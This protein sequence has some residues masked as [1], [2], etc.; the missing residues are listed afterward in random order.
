MTPLRVDLGGANRYT[1]LPAPDADPDPGL[2]V[3]RWQDRS[4]YGIDAVP[5]GDSM[6]VVTTANKNAMGAIMVPRVQRYFPTSGGPVLCTDSRMVQ[7]VRF[8]RPGE[9]CGLTPVSPS[10]RKYQASGSAP[11]I[12]PPGWGAQVGGELL[13]YPL[14]GVSFISVQP[15]ASIYVQNAAYPT[16]AIPLDSYEYQ[17]TIEMGV[18]HACDMLVTEESLTASAMASVPDVEVV[19]VARLYDP[20]AR[21]TLFNLAMPADGGYTGDG[22]F[23]VRF[24]SP[25]EH[26][27]QHNRDS[28]TF[29]DETLTLNSIP[30]HVSQQRAE[31]LWFIAAAGTD[32]RQSDA[33]PNCH[34]AATSRNDTSTSCPVEDHENSG[35]ALS[36][37]L[38]A[39]PRPFTYVQ[40]IYTNTNP[41]ASLP[42]K[43]R[44]SMAFPQSWNFSSSLS[45]QRQSIWLQGQ[46]IASDNSGHALSIPA[47]HVA[48]WGWG[49]GFGLDSNP[50][51]AQMNLHEFLV[52]FSPLNEAERAILNASL[53]AKW[54]LVLPPDVLQFNYPVRQ[55][56]GNDKTG[57]SCSATA[58]ADYRFLPFYAGIFCAH[59]SVWPWMANRQVL[60]HS[61]GGIGTVPTAAG[62]VQITAGSSG[63]LTLSSPV[64]V[65]GK[66]FLSTPA[67]D[68]AQS[69]FLMIVN[70]ELNAE[71][72]PLQFLSYPTPPALPVEELV[73]LRQDQ[74]ALLEFRGFNGDV[75]GVAEAS[76]TD[77][78]PLNHD[79]Y[80]NVGEQIVPAGEGLCWD[81][82]PGA[83]HLGVIPKFQWLVWPVN[84]DKSLAFGMPATRDPNGDDDLV[85]LTF[86]LAEMGYEKTVRQRGAKPGKVNGADPTIGAGEA[87]NPWPEYGLSYRLAFWL[88]FDFAYADIPDTR[89]V[90]EE[91]HHSASR[92]QLGTRFPLPICRPDGSCDPTYT[93]P[94][95]TVT[96]L[97]SGTT[98]LPMV[99]GDYDAGMA[100][101]GPT[102][103]NDS[104]GN[105]IHDGAEDDTV[106][107]TVDAGLFAQ[108]NS[109]SGLSE[110]V[111]TGARIPL[112]RFTL[113]IHD[114][115]DP[116]HDIGRTTPVQADGVGSR[117]GGWI[118]E[119]GV[120]FGLGG[121]DDL[122]SS[123]QSATRLR[124]GAA[125]N[126]RIN[127]YPKPEIRWDFAHE[128]RLSITVT[129][130]SGEVDQPSTAPAY[131]LRQTNSLPVRTT[132]R[133]AL[134]RGTEGN[135]IGYFVSNA[136]RTGSPG[137]GCNE[138]PDYQRGTS[139]ASNIPGG[140]PTLHIP[141]S[142]K[143]DAYYPESAGNTFQAGGNHGAPF[144]NASEDLGCTA[145]IYIYNLEDNVF[146]GERD[147]T[148]SVDNTSLALQV[149]LLDNDPAPVIVVMQPSTL[150]LTEQE[151]DPSNPT[152]V[153]ILTVQSQSAGTRAAIGSPATV[154][155]RVVPG[156]TTAA[157]ED[158]VL[159]QTAVIAAGSDTAEAVLRAN[160]NGA[161]G[162]SKTVV[163]EV[164]LGERLAGIN[165]AAGQQRQYT[166]TIE[167]NEAA[168]FSLGPEEIDLD[169]TGAPDFLNVSLGSRPIRDL[170]V[171][172]S[173][174]TG[175]TS[176]LRLGEDPM[177]ALAAVDLTFSPSN[178][179]VPQRVQATPVFDARVLD[180]ETIITVAVV[181]AQAD[182]PY[183][184]LAAETVPVAVD[185]DNP[186]GFAVSP[187]AL[188]IL[189]SVGG[190]VQVDT[191]S[192]QLLAQPSYVQ[193]AACM[194]S[195]SCETVV[196]AVANLAPASSC[197]EV[198]IEDLTDAQC[199]ASVAR[200]L[201]FTPSNWNI[202]QTVTVETVDD[203]I[204][205]D[206]V[207]ALTVRYDTSQSSPITSMGS[208]LPHSF[209]SPAPSAQDV[210]ITLVNDDVAG[211]RLH[212]NQSVDELGRIEIDESGIDSIGNIL[213][214]LG[215]QPENG[216]VIEARVMDGGEAV[217]RLTDDPA[218]YAVPGQ[219]VSP[220]AWR[221]S[222]PVGIAGIDDDFGFDRTATV[223][224]DAAASA[225]ATYSVALPLAVEVL[226]V[227]NDERPGLA[228]NTTAVTVAEPQSG[229]IPQRASIVVR[230][231]AR[232]QSPVGVVVESEDPGEVS[233]SLRNVQIIQPEDWDEG[234]TFTVFGINDENKGDDI[235]VVTVAVEQGDT[236]DASFHTAPSTILVT[237]TD[238]EQAGFLVHAAD[239]SEIFDAEV[240]ESLSADATPVVL[241]ASLQVPPEMGT[242]QVVLA[243]SVRDEGL[244][245][246]E[247]LL[248]D[249]AQ[250]A[251]ACAD[252]TL[253][254]STVTLTFPFNDW[255][256]PQAF[257]AC[258]VNDDSF[259]AT[260]VTLRFDSN[261]PSYAVNPSRLLP[262][263]I[264]DDEIAGVS[265]DPTAL[266]IAEGSS[267]TFE[268]TLLSQPPPGDF[269]LFQISACTTLAAS[270]TE[271]DFVLLSG[272]FRVSNGNLDSLTA[273]LTVT[274]V[275]D[276][277]IG[278][279]TLSLRLLTLAS[280]EFGELT[281]TPLSVT[282]EDDDRIGFATTSSQLTMAEGATASYSFTLL[283]CP[284]DGNVVVSMGV[285]DPRADGEDPAADALR[286]AFDGSVTV[287]PE[288]ITLNCASAGQPQIVAVTANDDMLF[289]DRSMLANA[290]RIDHTVAS[291]DSR[292]DDVAR[293]LA[294]VR[295]GLGGVPDALLAPVTVQVTNDNDM[296]TVRLAQETIGEEFTE[297]NEGSASFQVRQ[298]TRAES[299][300]R[301]TLEDL[302]DAAAQRGADYILVPMDDGG[303]VII[304]PYTLETPVMV[305][306]QDDDVYE[307]TERLGILATAVEGARLS[308]VAAER[309]VSFQILDDELIPTVSLSLST[310]E[311]PERQSDDSPAPAVVLTAALGHETTGTV[312]VIIDVISNRDDLP[313]SYP[314]RLSVNLADSA[315][316]LPAAPSPD[317]RVGSSVDIGDDGNPRIVLSV[318]A[319]ALTASTDIFVIAD[320]EIDNELLWL[321]IAQVQGPAVI[322]SP[323]S[324]ATL[325]ILEDA[326]PPVI[327]VTAT[328]TAE[329]VS[330]AKV[331]FTWH[332]ATDALTLAAELV[333]F[334]FI[335]DRPF[336]P[337]A[338]VLDDESRIGELSRQ[339]RSAAGLVYPEDVP[340][341]S[342]LTGFVSETVSAVVVHE[343]LLPSSS[344]YATVMVQDK[345]GN[346]SLYSA[347][348]ISFSTDAPEDLNGDGLADHLSDVTATVGFTDTDRDGVS[349]AVEQ[350]LV[351][352]LA[353]LGLVAD[354][355]SQTA[356]SALTDGNENGIPD[357]VEA[358]LGLPL[359]FA[360]A[361]AI[362]GDSTAR[363]VVTVPPNE[364]AMA[365]VS[366][367]MNTPVRVTV[368]AVDGERAMEPQPYFRR[369]QLCGARPADLN[370]DILERAV[371]PS[372]YPTA[373]RPVPRAPDGAL[374]LRPGQNRIWWIAVD[375]DGNWPLGG[376][377]AQTI[378]VLPQVSFQ[379]DH[380]LPIGTDLPIILALDGDPVFLEGETTLLQF[381]FRVD[382]DDA[383][384]EA[385]SN[386][387]DPQIVEIEQNERMAVFMARSGNSGAAILNLV[388]G[389]PPFAQD[390]DRIDLATERVV[391]GIKGQ[392]QVVTV[393]DN[394]P[395]V[396]S[397][398]V[399]QGNRLTTGINPAGIAVLEVRSSVADSILDRP[400]L[401]WDWSGTSP[402]LLPTE[403]SIS[404]FQSNISNLLRE[405]PGV[406]E[407]FRVAV[408]VSDGENAVLR[409][410]TVRVERVEEILRAD[411]DSDGDGLADADEGRTDADT[412]GIPNY[413]D[414]LT[415][416]AHVLQSRRSST[417]IVP[418]PDRYL[419]AARPGFRMRLG[420]VALR[421]AKET[422]VDL[423]GIE[424]SEREHRFT[425]RVPLADV[426]PGAA[427]AGASVPVDAVG[428]YDFL[429]DGIGV[430]DS[431]AVTLPLAAPAPATPAYSQYHAARG[432][433]IF[434]DRSGDRALSLPGVDGFCPSPGAKAWE[435]AGELS[436][437]HRCV[438]LSLR[439]G[440]P[441]DVDG[442]A[443]GV[444]AHLGGVAQSILLSGIDAGSSGGSGAGGGCALVGDARAADAAL[445]LLLLLCLLSRR[446]RNAPAVALAVALT[447][448]LLP[449]GARGADAGPEWGATTG[450]LLRNVYFGAGLASTEVAPGLFGSRYRLG[451][452]NDSGPRL[453]LGY[454]LASHWSL[455]AFWADLGKA[456][457][458]DTRAAAP[459]Y[460]DYRERGALLSYRRA[461]PAWLGLGRGLETLGVAWGWFV[462][463]GWSDQNAKC[464][465]CQFANVDAGQPVLGLGIDVA[466]PS[467]WTVRLHYER[468]GDDASSVALSWLFGAAAAPGGGR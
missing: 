81:F 401:T 186:P 237:V 198:L 70:G 42:Q 90:V 35:A 126:L 397:L 109:L 258:A 62:P 424:D 329:V 349:D 308:G 213:I 396:V 23:R 324:T 102:A 219:A 21:Q 263:K 95:G 14:A 153:A 384:V 317:Y 249:G 55:Q 156:M 49:W 458:I 312:T 52:F 242:S 191:F 107:F 386:I 406:V 243:V 71:N 120:W 182:D 230:L 445:A 296:P 101:I 149:T 105:G 64:G 65:D 292:Y 238:N 201:T 174:P 163:V 373:C 321:Q 309:Q 262:V 455:E 3:Q 239:G 355:G 250:S 435:A 459:A 371:L 141:R 352:R 84:I 323:P 389:S 103:A 416:D 25:Y 6:R 351:N 180:R 173:I 465:G 208:P 142:Y 195:V 203:S 73:N 411:L 412:D 164:S 234:F 368:S 177:Q 96:T 175:D 148:L 354:A 453:A 246:G 289:Q 277:V 158:Y 85:T 257:T 111:G 327:A 114:L 264:L 245:G 366:L 378:S 318:A 247:L 457:I 432:W 200:R 339:A 313:L 402:A 222:R 227:S 113:R 57:V 22:D 270:C 407:V 332:A 36:V 26:E 267:A 117:P 134:A 92:C 334:L 336:E 13:V 345:I 431:L 333:Y 376:A 125:R 215:S 461:R 343:R 404:S 38:G 340:G 346:V 293:Q 380:R 379:R 442:A 80:L 381:A 100:T 190:A 223:L 17:C 280:Q 146:T 29:P 225:D 310:N 16:S 68:P 147:I 347:T 255:N 434:D 10:N 229:S 452:T 372:N 325:S 259:E 161:T 97:P 305:M 419:L 131:A 181:G 361:S 151:G 365:F 78:L 248:A 98:G 87:W 342:P 4:G 357:V 433:Q 193:S 150:I 326:D 202:S 37:A 127:L 274:S 171:R 281:Q 390:P 139:R 145:T 188:T 204:D 46:E 301:V 382:S 392:M 172:V 228:L 77:C 405:S 295:A 189:E 40:S 61:L 273:A 443:N 417:D 298:D 91:L 303:V 41:V 226:V 362:V 206:D 363:P 11:A 316:T 99:H 467:L 374:M 60:R 194:V 437:G 154:L 183:Q 272:P 66:D 231:L 235:G 86:N 322:T 137:A 448:V 178:W 338:E 12:N 399:R 185:N 284:E 468:Y 20:N 184:T 199:R 414:T 143:T 383:Q 110:C 410:M 330:G 83:A 82:Y 2:L 307:G 218:R 423:L 47:G 356:V 132:D 388:S 69:K 76:E 18:G 290:Y 300:T 192:V 59:R 403:E 211:A 279:K 320:E 286:A 464:R 315:S 420:A 254:S 123:A 438:R 232:P 144:Y 393:P 187:R 311:I 360:T 1:V 306:A 121:R 79:S 138:S 67:A 276:R 269:A 122:D 162:G 106:S 287:D 335:G 27:T 212:E 319:N 155:F 167:D 282:I 176:I 328:I 116:V 179:A 33:A 466:A 32:V 427:V 169:E 375:E 115:A 89:R 409:S 440:G 314:D 302:P 31:K 44:I 152:N 266:T 451:S 350:Y 415:Y 15:G 463:A 240:P 233:V 50:P 5:V 45:Q 441:N 241:G 353:P 348:G 261:T 395:P 124:E 260:D 43:T 275:D 56:L 283:S 165:F 256:I 364:R 413:L 72:I 216:V 210:Q 160:D 135:T 462:S 426:A 221:V 224:L 205:R 265:F 236:P 337:L 166:F 436:E 30:G 385:A 34:A 358:S 48:S 207:A 291:A 108:R 268:V 53:A 19:M 331:R 112:A 299:P 288:Q 278:D 341:A 197:A 244:Q 28:R 400:Q 449:A 51:S 93:S 88:G 450:S 133:D 370:A 217:L 136:N 387:R 170:L 444:V 7:T 128:Y 425:A 294:H 367:G 398:S 118:G 196:L 119:E 104:N 220:G 359:S 168:R 422:G 304:A 8:G 209:S 58:N 446:R 429:V 460:A 285:V 271:Q 391:L 456:E 454:R 94:A 439:D 39:D 75:P 252:M 129:P 430:G 394:L 130:P 140:I 428:V 54:G 447:L 9:S 408:S 418:D 157:P 74:T 421:R 63:P 297:R 344:Y 159:Q 24:S 377:S 253:F 251:N 214:R 369:G